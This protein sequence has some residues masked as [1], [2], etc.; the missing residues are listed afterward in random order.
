MD[1]QQSL[2]NAASGSGQ[3]K[4]DVQPIVSATETQTQILSTI[5]QQQLAVAV[6]GQDNSKAILT[7]MQQLAATGGWASYGRLNF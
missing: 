3:L 5:M 6:A 7:A 4:F 1:Y 2:Y